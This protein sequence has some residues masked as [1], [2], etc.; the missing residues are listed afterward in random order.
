MSKF[1]VTFRQELYVSLKVVFHCL[2]IHCWKWDCGSLGELTAQCMGP[3]RLCYCELYD[4]RDGTY[5]LRI[6]PN[7]VG[8]H[9]LVVKYSGDHVPGSPFTV[10]VSH[11]PD[12]SKVSSVEK[13]YSITHNILHFSTLFAFL[14]FYAKH[15]FGSSPQ[16][17]LLLNIEEV[18]ASFLQSP[19]V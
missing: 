3:S 4:H 14:Q 8:K 6:R 10:N 1:V 15:L 7:E 19:S 5:S 11:P 17:I 12:P 16:V 18:W 13:P 2:K 9:T